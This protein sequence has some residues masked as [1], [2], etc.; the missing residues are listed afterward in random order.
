MRRAGGEIAVMQIVGFDARFDKGAHQRGERVDIV[1]D[2]FE[3]NALADQR[4]SAVG[5]VAGTRRAASGVN[6]RG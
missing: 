1:V 6:S 3:Q 5:Q 2:P 4:D